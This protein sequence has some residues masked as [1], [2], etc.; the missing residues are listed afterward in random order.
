VHLLTGRGS[1]MNAFASRIETSKLANAAALHGAT[2]SLINSCIVNSRASG[3]YCDATTNSTTT[4]SIAGSSHITVND[5][6]VLGNKLAGVE[7][8]VTLVGTNT[9][10]GNGVNVL[11]ST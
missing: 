1:A 5:C 3:V 11:A 4:D 7:G 9:I 10:S 8:A 6:S 2:L